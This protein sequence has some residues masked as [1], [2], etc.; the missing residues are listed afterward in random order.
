MTT[1][2]FFGGVG[3]IGSSKVEVAEAG[4]R[5]LF[6]LGP[7]IPGRDGL[8]RPPV[9]SRPGSG[10]RDQIRVGEAPAIPFLY[11][12]EALAGL[13]VEGGADG[14]SAL[15]I[16]HCHIDHMG[17]IG[18]VDPAV[19]IYASPETIAMVDA[20]E[21]A[22]LGLDG[23]RPTLRPMAEGEVV[24]VGPLRVRRYPVDHDVAGASG[25]A[26]ETEDGLV[27]YTG[28]FRLHGR[29]PELTWAFAQAVAGAEALVTEGTTLSFGG[30][31]GVRREADCDRAFDRALGETPGLVMVTLYPRN[32]ERVQAFLA[33]A[34][35]HGRTILW[36]PAMGAFLR[37]FGLEGIVDFGSEGADAS[38]VSAAPDRF[39][40]QIEVEHLADLLD[41]PVGPGSVL[42]HANGE[43]LGPFQPTWDVLQDWLR[44][45]ATPFRQIGAGGH[46]DPDDL[47][48]FVETVAPETV[49]PLH[50]D[51]PFRLLPPP[52]TL[53]ILPRYAK[54][55]PVARRTPEPSARGAARPTGSLQAAVPGADDG[56]G[57][58]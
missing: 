53:R 50:T 56:R 47:H 46:A 28:D 33:I 37:A 16:S 9:R 45:T 10:L 38:A 27:A 25:Y 48:H 51:D 7:L 52:G 17:L 20:L 24:Q 5:A 23:G 21:V 3:S 19:P 32:I 11:R 29:H 13:D 1:L 6:D 58:R 2:R 40:V 44:Y 15:F 54:T 4:W 36:P 8:L 30:R 41:L 26:I 39:V 57:H 12:P 42:C 22:G 43:P 49:Y 31:G 18:W 34:A 35:A 14:R 55:Y